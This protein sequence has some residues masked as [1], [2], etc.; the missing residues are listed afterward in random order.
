MQNLTRRITLTAAFMG[1]GWSAAPAIAGGLEYAAEVDSCLA[2]VNDRVD[3]QSANRVRH[4]VTQSRRT[5]IGYALTIE[6]AVYR[7]GGERHYAV[8][9]VVRG[10]SQPIKLR[11]APVSL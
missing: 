8:H 5:A 11:I 9:C 7:P 10:S 4:L 2:A 6:T 1:L 3:V